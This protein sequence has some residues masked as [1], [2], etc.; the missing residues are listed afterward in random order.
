MQTNTKALLS[1]IVIMASYPSVKVQFRLFSQ[2]NWAN[3]NQIKH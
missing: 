3:Y 1:S 2:N